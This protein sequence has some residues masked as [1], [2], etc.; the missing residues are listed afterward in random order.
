M[1]TALCY[2][3]IRSPSC[4]LWITDWRLRELTPDDA[5]MSQFGQ[6]RIC[7]NQPSHRADTVS[8]RRT[9]RHDIVPSAGVEL[10]WSDPAAPATDDEDA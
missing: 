2:K 6:R 1:P 3:A 5:V 7:R 4:R 9:V 8:D 10:L